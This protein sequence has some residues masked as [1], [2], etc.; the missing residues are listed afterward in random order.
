MINIYQP[1]L[2]HEELKAIKKVFKSNW[3]GKGK[4]EEQFKNDISLKLRA[5]SYEWGYSCVNVDNILTINS[6]TEALFQILE[7]LDLNPT[8]NVVIPSISFI[9]VA[10]AIK[11]SN[12]NIKFCDVDKHTLNVE[13]S[14]LEKACDENTKAVILLHY[15]GVPCDL[16]PILKFCKENNIIVIED[17]ANS[18]FSMYKGRSTGVIG[19]YGTW[20]FDSMKIL[21]MGDG[22]L[23]YAKD[24]DNATK[25]NENTYLGLLNSSGYSNKID[26]KWWEYNVSGPGRR[27]VI[28]DISAAI[29]I[30]QLKKVNRFIKKR[31]KIHQ[32]YNEHLKDLNWLKLPPAIS[33]DSDSSYYMYHIQ[34]E[35]SDRDKLASYLKEKGIYTTF[36]YYPLHWVAYYNK[37]FSYVS[38]DDLP[39]T[40]YAANHTLCIPIHQSLKKSEIK[41]IVKT[42]KDYGKTK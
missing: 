13:L 19:D 32:Y 4:L 12:A 18:P 37:R 36:R 39:N 41:Y 8:D 9:G 26:A 33:L 10:N 2:G 38:H 31:K 22:G 3:I 11:K 40:E 5:D 16:D 25:L 20:S 27:S 6:C 28:N 15:A 17:N 14:Y 23:I 30:E 24:K 35:T 34:L 21:S 1:E 7:L 42:I 29:G